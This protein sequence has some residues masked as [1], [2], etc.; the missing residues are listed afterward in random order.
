VDSGVL[1]KA[2][3]T[4]APCPG[5]KKKFK[6][7][8][9]YCTSILIMKSRNTLR[10]LFLYPENSRVVS[11]S[12]LKMLKHKFTKKFSWLSAPSLQILVTPMGL[13][14]GFCHHGHKL[15]SFL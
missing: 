8:K 4:S 12:S 10:K 13:I 15:L 7:G 14:S 6:K 2:S 9:K 11:K 3:H 1:L 5:L